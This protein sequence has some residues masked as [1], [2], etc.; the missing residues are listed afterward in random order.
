MLRVLCIMFCDVPCFMRHAHFLY[1]VFWVPTIV[2]SE[3]WMVFFMDARLTFYTTLIFC[4]CKG[5][6]ET[7]IRRLT[8][9]P[10]GWTLDATQVCVM[11]SVKMSI[12]N[13]LGTLSD[14]F[15]ISFQFILTRPCWSTQTY[16]NGCTTEWHYYY[17][18]CSHYYCIV[19]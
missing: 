15:V 3:P 7:K 18:S 12:M 6:F 9:I 2:C 1:V 13:Y 8:I 11:Q 14:L 16:P 10:V 4:S 17:N 5:C 19:A